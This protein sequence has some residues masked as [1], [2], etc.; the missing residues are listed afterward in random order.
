MFSVWF[1]RLVRT[2]P[3]KDRKSVEH[4]MKC[5]SQIAL[6]VEHA[7]HSLHRI[8]VVSFHAYSS[9]HDLHNVEESAAC[10]DRVGILCERDQ[11]RS[12]LVERPAITAQSVRDT[13][14]GTGTGAGAGAGTGVGAG[15]GAG[16]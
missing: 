8:D 1:C 16:A 9:E 3:E 5:Q 12:E 14:A 13:G 6:D 2:Y 15:A 10:D 4:F 11:L 7:T